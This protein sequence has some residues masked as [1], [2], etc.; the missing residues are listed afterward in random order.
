MLFHRMWL[1]LIAFLALEIA[2]EVALRSLRVSPEW[3]TVTFI[4]LQVALGFEAAGLRR[5]TL[6]RKGWRMIGTVTGDSTLDSE[7]RFFEAWLM[8]PAPAVAAAV[9]ATETEERQPIASAGWFRWPRFRRA[10][11]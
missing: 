9:P 5:W 2:L 4:A 3:V 6:G 8:E 11:R 1:I 10:S 7:R